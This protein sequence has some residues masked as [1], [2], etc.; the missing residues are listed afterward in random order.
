MVVPRKSIAAKVTGSNVAIFR[1]D[2]SVMD[3]NPALSPVV[4]R[5]LVAA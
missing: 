3:G 1:A 5:E 4:T 2:E